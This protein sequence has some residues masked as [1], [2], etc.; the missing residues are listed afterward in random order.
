MA[1]NYGLRTVAAI[2][3]SVMAAACDSSTAPPISESLDTD[4]AIADFEALETVFARR[5]ARV[6]CRRDRVSLVAHRRRYALPH[7]DCL[8][9]FQT[10]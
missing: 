4:A 1:K 8:R 6:E 7:R 3:V 2:A 5:R 9:R 10:T